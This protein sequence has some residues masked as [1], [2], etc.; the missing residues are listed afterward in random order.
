[1]KIYI[2]PVPK[3]VQPTASGFHYPAHNWDYSVEQDFLI[4]LK[5]HQHLLTE[6]PDQADWHYLPIFW[7]RLYWHKV[8]ETNDY[9]HTLEHLNPL[10][11]ELIIDDRK[12]FTVCQLEGIDQQDSQIGN[13]N[14]GQ[15]LLLLNGRREVNKPIID[16][17]LLSKPHRQLIRKLPKKYITC[18]NGKL[19]TH[20]QRVEIADRLS[21]RNDVH[22]AGYERDPGHHLRWLTGRTFVQNIL[23][24]SVALAPR[25][26]C[27]SSFRFFEAMQ[28]GVVP[29][30]VGDIDIRPFR[31]SIKWNEV[32]FF[33]ETVA[34]LESLLNSLD[35][36]Q[37][38]E[39]GQKAYACWNQ[40]LRYQK[41]CPYAIAELEKVLAIRSEQNSLKA[42][43][44]DFQP[45][46]THPQ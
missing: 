38:L 34:E 20:P 29:C 5:R 8:L 7:Y 42:N 43:D 15:S 36:Q 1:M 28:L 13:I 45:N 31:Q 4:Y 46:L 9:S 24:S 35:Q 17:P 10:I 18:F 33:V 26:T 19:N 11:E 16:I 41:W 2:I 40:H 32:S 23:R 27:A 39:M 25:G 6:S 44:L 14:L 22:I 30:L 12:T 3:Q 37:A 21:S